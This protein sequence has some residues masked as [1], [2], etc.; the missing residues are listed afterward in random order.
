MASKLSKE[1]FKAEAVKRVAGM[2]VL[3]QSSRRVVER[4]EA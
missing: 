2:V 1:E 4:V 3:S